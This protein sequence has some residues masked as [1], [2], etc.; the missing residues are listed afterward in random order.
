MTKNE[1]E[2]DNCS[3]TY[4]TVACVY[5]NSLLYVYDCIVLFFAELH[6]NVTKI[7]HLNRNSFH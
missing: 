1:F 5:S 4:Y 2:Q 7:C 6:N 3:I